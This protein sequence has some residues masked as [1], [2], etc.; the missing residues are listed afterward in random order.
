VAVIETGMKDGKWQQRCENLMEEIRAEMRAT[1]RYTG[2]DHLGERVEAVMLQV[3]RHLFVPLWSRGSA[4][5]NYPLPIG[6]GQTISQPYIVALMTD[7]LDLE[8]DDTVLEIG[9]GCGYQTA[10]LAQLCAHVCSIE[11]IPELATKAKNTLA[12]LGFTNIDIRVGN[13]YDGWP[14]PGLF[15]AIIVTAAAPEV[16]DSLLDRLKPGGRMVI[17]VGMP[18]ATQDLLRLQR[19]ADGEVVGRPLLPVAFVPMVR[20]D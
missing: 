1:S 14:E 7:L 6:N 16:P 5:G 19:Q 4:Y 2:R 3:P 18:G 9:T 8:P 13:G 10:V 20:T 17:P 11:V 15:D 12:D